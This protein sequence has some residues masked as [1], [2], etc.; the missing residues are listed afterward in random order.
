[1]ATASGTAPARAAGPG[2]SMPQRLQ[3]LR[4]VRAAG[5]WLS[6]AAVI[7]ISLRIATAGVARTSFLLAGGRHGPHPSWL[8]GP[9]PALGGQ[10]TL[11]AFELLICG[12]A[13]AWLMTLLCAAALPRWAVPATIVVTTLIFTLAPPLLSQDVFNYIAYGRLQ[14]HGINPYAHG[15]AA[16][17]HDPVY[18]FTGH[19]WKHAPSAYGPLFTLIS[20]ALAPLG[21][22]VSLWAMKALAGLA[23]LGTAGLVWLT[24][25][26]LG[27]SPA[28][29]AAFFALNPLVLLYA[30]PGAH[31]DLPMAFFVALSVYL[32]VC[33][34]AAW[35]GAT[36]VA[37]MAIK[38]SAGLAAPFLLLGV[39]P[40]R[41]VLAGLA[42]AGAVVAAGTLALYGT[43]P[44]NI[45]HVLAFE[46]K[47]NWIVISVPG[48][49]GSLFGFG[50]LTPQTKHLLFGLF[51]ASAVAL[52]VYSRR[53]RSWLE[54]AGAATVVLLATTAWLLPWY[55]VWVLP[56]AAVIR[57]RA[58]SA[59][60]VALTLLLLAMQI[61]HY[62]LTRHSHH[63]HHGVVHAR[64]RT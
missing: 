42:A 20:A 61:D 30:L 57:P 7:A 44:A 12:L 26:R 9:L 32:A 15:P 50:P 45:V 28:F 16:L 1:M 38:L 60:V 64:T 46:Q 49:V 53:G 18:P 21:T 31:N 4:L 25:R 36:L 29:A 8:I 37:A 23:T 39:R 27:R 63:H 2:A 19:L 59:A 22:A 58:V 48:F 35:A 24:A 34:R 6:L 55:I 43:A 13:A 52:I 5:G 40:R 62:V 54:A 51:A 41:R 47:V 14:I 3:I 33:G 56:L 11:N 10:L 17:S